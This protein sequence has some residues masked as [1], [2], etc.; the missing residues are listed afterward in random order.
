LQK[1]QPDQDVLE[2]SVN[3]VL[4]YNIELMKKLFAETVKD[5]FDAR[6]NAIVKESAGKKVLSGYDTSEK[7]GKWAL[8]HEKAKMDYVRLW[9]KKR[10]I[11]F[12]EARSEIQ[13]PWSEIKGNHA[14]LTVYQTL[15][16]GYI[17]PGSTTVNHFGIGTRH[18][19]KMKK[20]KGKWL[21][22]QD[23]YTDGLGDDSLAPHPKPADGSPQEQPPKQTSPKDAPGLY[24]RI[25]AVSYADQYAG[26]A[27]GA[28]N[29]NQYNLQQYGDLNPIGGD[30][31]NYVS[32][33]LSDEKGGKL[34]LDGSWFYNF[35][36]KG[37]NGSQAW[38]RAD[39]F[40][41]WLQYSGHGRLLAQGTFPELIKPAQKQPAG[42][43]GELKKGDVIGYGTDGD[44]EH[45]AIVVGWDS[46]GYP[47][48]NSHTVDRYHCPWDMG[49]DQKTIYYLYQITS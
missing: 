17:Y 33:C 8:S 35:D 22:C 39:S 49:Y 15:Q 3:H 11:K 45:V 4:E 30:C 29:D 47:L 18:W 27:W 12:T 7:L 16:V 20:H 1:V 5:V 13:I 42:V 48:V 21:I 25:G 10:G 43:I 37:F 14:E 9:E 40:C 23:F 41:N 26:L 19:M 28:G 32:Q 6:A 34:P 46:K 38:V 31:A 24:D 2:Q 44:I 36:E